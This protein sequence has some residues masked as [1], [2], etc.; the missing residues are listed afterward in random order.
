LVTRIAQLVAEDGDAAGLEPDHG[1]TRLDLVAQLTEDLL[2]QPARARDETVIV[3][4]PAA[5]QRCR[6]HH[7]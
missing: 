7:L 4:R 5:A 2:Q 1:R 6:R 3:E